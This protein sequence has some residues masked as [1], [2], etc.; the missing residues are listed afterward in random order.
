MAINPLTGKPVK[1]SLTTLRK[2]ARAL[3]INYEGLSFD[4]LKPIV[5]K[6]LKKKFG[7]GTLTEEPAPKAKVKAIVKNKKVAKKEYTLK[8]LCEQ[9]GIEPKAARR[10]LRKIRGANNV[11]Y[12]FTSDEAKKVVKGKSFEVLA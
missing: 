12:V 1:K 9:V 6:A 8:E 10:V 7:G 3:G 11:A 5:E 2:H 4:E